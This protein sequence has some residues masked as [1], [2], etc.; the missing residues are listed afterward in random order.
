MFADFERAVRLWLVPQPSA[1][2]ED[3][4]L[5]REPSFAG[6]LLASSSAVGT[7]SAA[8]RIEP[9][10]GR[11]PGPDLGKLAEVDMPAAA[12]SRSTSPLR[13]YLQGIPE[14]QAAASASAASASSATFE[15]F[16]HFE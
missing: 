3:T 14:W 13:S 10:E 12:S 15:P 5:E 9:A 8:D 4:S 7:S 11:S 6:W 1:T 16:S 2:V